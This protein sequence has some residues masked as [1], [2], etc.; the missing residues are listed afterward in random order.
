M[1]GE[2]GK[3]SKPRPY[4]VTQDQFAQNWD[5]IFGRKNEKETTKPTDETVE[6]SKSGDMDVSGLQPDTHS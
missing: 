2:A 6:S 1:S 3:G 4:S 5:K